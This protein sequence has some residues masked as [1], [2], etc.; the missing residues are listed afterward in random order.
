MQY[1][2][3]RRLFLHLPSSCFHWRKK[4]NEIQ[5]G[6]ELGS[7]EFWSDVPTT[8]RLSSGILELIVHIHIHCLTLRLALKACMVNTEVQLAMTA[9][10]RGCR[11]AAVMSGC[12]GTADALV[13]DCEYSSGLVVRAFD[14]NPGLSLD[15]IS[16]SFFLQ[17]LGKS[18]GTRISHTTKAMTTIQ[19][20][21]T[22]EKHALWVLHL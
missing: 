15:L 20:F 18:L 6:V 7:S 19:W 8:E 13:C 22:V 21:N 4:L 14:W 3:R 17:K 12:A 11:V 5:P 16:L 1:D 9:A 2:L 10:T